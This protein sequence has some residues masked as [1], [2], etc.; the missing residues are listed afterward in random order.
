MD[1]DF[2]NRLLAIFR[3]ETREH[4]DAI[5]AG[6][7]ELEQLPA[8]ESGQDVIEAVFREAHSLKGAARAVNMAGIEAV[9][10][11]LES[12]FAALKLRTIAPSSELFD[13]LHQAVDAVATLIAPSGTGEDARQ[14][15]LLQ[16]LGQRL[17][18]AAKGPLMPVAPLAPQA[19]PAA[20]P[21]YK[22]QASD[23]T[24]RIA[25][26]KLDGI[27]NQAEEM[28]TAKL[29]VAQRATELG[30]LDRILADW[31]KG[32]KK[33]Q[34]GLRSMRKIRQSPHL[35]AGLLSGE[36]T[37]TLLDFLDQQ[38][39]FVRMVRQRVLHTAKSIRNDRHSLAM[40]VDSIHEAARQVLMLPFSTLGEILPKA[41]RD[42]ARDLAKDAVLM[43]S[44]DS[45]EIDKRIL[46]GL[47]DPLL[48]LVRNCV[49]HGIEPPEERQRHGKPPRGTVSV[50]IALAGS[51]RI[52]ISVGDDGAGI[53]LARLKNAAA[54]AGLITREDAESMADG[55]ALDLMFRSGL[56]TSAMITDVS[57]RG[58]GL[59]IVRE[60]VEGLGGGVSV[61]TAPRQ[62]TSFHL[63]L[64]L[65]LSTFRGVLVRA[66]EQL[67]VV[68]TA[69]LARVGRVGRETVK[70]VEGL[71]TIVLDGEA[72]SFVRLAEVLGLPRIEKRESNGGLLSFFLLGTGEKRIAF[73]VDQVIDELEVL[74]KGLG[75][76]LS[77]VR[78]FAGATVL[79]TGKV[80]PILHCNDLLKSAVKVSVSALPQVSAGATNEEARRTVLVVEDS[81]TARTLLKNI[82]ETAGYL[83]TT[84][85]DGLDALAQLRTGD[86]DLV[87]SDVDMPRMNGFELTAKI[88]SASSFADLPVVL[89][90]SLDSREDRERGIEVGANAY[91]V[92]SS[93]DQSNLLEVIKR[94]I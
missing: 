83:T 63:S 85:V 18:G 8:Q 36:K 17:A 71:E 69:S 81:I 86:Y 21:P 15:S 57:G 12:V 72:T 37:A 32:W 23:Q 3:T 54:Q 10:H 75:P 55:E 60:K 92:K 4:L 89:V 19:E 64:P 1:N 11:S 52:E 46:E 41:V 84:A 73:G 65:T 59:A 62:G 67:F 74:A 70:S 76:Q 93:F 43:V 42:L 66:E 44:G 33:S 53:D 24:V 61:T 88:R 20:P 9:S 48:H 31:E 34:P 25:S 6:L 94:F 58:L 79:G 49:A 26:A 5:S 27:L 91:I 47:K 50:E 22:R 16:V 7:L 2:H 78:N 39:S 28:V 82:L 90:T 40:M 80:V 68:P 35:A 51:N 14:T 30:E 45:I 38:H 29:A 77:R 87:V 56:S 13:L